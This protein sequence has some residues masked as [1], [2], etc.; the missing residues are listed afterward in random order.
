[1]ANKPFIIDALQYSKWSKTIFQQMNNSGVA[2]VHVTIAYH[3]N[4]LEMVN[5]IIAW[6]RYFEEY[7]NMII[8]G[9]AT[10]D[11]CRAHN[12]GKTAIIFG[13][14]NCSPIVDNLG[15]LDICHQLG[16]R[17][18]QLSYNNQSL[19]ATG[20]Y[21]TSDAG[22]TR[23][24]RQVIREMNRL[25]M[26]IDMSHSSSVSTLEAINHSARPIAIT[27]ANPT[28]WHNALRNK[29]DEVL[30]RLSENGGMLGFSLYPHHLNNGSD[31]SIRDF[32]LMV[33]KTAE[34]IGVDNIGFGSD[35]CQNQPDSIVKWMRNGTWTKD[36]EFGEGTKDAPGFP[37]QPKWFQSNI[38]FHNIINELKQIGFSNSEVEKI[39]GKNWLNFYEGYF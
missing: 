22:I 39:S 5:N 18:M 19:L 3:E 28:F 16:V 33:A 11:I 32:C 27:H 7:S 14:Q 12:E 20:C 17:I 21:E 15:L 36:V 6:N 31:C 13:F 25:G 2:G 1:M 4:F 8:H 35:L 26:I 24:G 10:E 9:R 23:M 29:S 30:N 34:K 37:D 38:D